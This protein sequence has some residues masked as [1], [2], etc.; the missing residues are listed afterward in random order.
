MATGSDATSVD[1]SDRISMRQLGQIGIA[2]CSNDDLN[3]L[4]IGPSTLPTVQRTAAALI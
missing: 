4:T 1:R 3:Q 2:S